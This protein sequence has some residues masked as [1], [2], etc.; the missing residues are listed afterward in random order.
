[1]NRMN[2]KDQATLAEAV[3]GIRNPGGGMKLVGH[4][5]ESTNSGDTWEVNFWIGPEMFR[6]A[7]CTEER[8][9]QIAV[10]VRGQLPKGATVGVVLRT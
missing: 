3:E 10:L 6:S 5:F 7:P 1:M 2:K 8:A 4:G 9:H